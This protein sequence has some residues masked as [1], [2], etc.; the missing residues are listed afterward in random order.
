V[1]AEIT[2]HGAQRTMDQDPNRALRAAHDLADL[3]RAHLLHEPEHQS[4]ATFGGQPV[5]GIPRPFR[6]VPCDSG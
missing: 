3:A 5:D 6:L 2:G 4:L 1:P